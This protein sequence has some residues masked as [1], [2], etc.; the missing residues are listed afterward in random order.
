[1]SRQRTQKTISVRIDRTYIHRPH[2]WRRI[3]RSAVF[4]AV[5]GAIVFLA[6]THAGGEGERIHNPG[7]LTRVHASFENNCAACHDGCDAQGHP[8][9]KFSLAVSDTA[10]LK[11]HDAGVH[12]ANQA[13]M[14][15]MDMSRHPPAAR[16]A[17]CASCHVEHRGQGA[18]VTDSDM[19]CVGCHADLTGKTLKTP[20]TP[21]H[22]TDFSLEGHPRFGRALMKGGKLV[23]PTVLAF[24]H[25]KHLSGILK[26]E[27]QN[28]TF[29]HDPNPAAAQSLTWETSKSA[30]AMPDDDQASPRPLADG[31]GRHRS[32]TQVNF[33]KNCQSCHDLGTLPGSDMA[34]PHE[35]LGQIRRLILT[36]VT[37]SSSPWLKMAPDKTGPR[38][39]AL[40]DRIISALNVP[41]DYSDAVD[42]VSQAVK[43]APLSA[44][45]NL[46]A[47]PLPADL[48]AKLIAAAAKLPT[49]VVAA[50]DKKNVAAALAS[51]T[52]PAM[53]LRPLVISRLRDA[54]A[55]GT[56]GDAKQKILAEFDAVFARYNQDTPDPRLL[57]MYVIYANDA[58]SCV[59]CHTMEG[60]AAGVPTEWMSL[61]S[62]TKT[63][64]ASIFRTTP[65]GIPAGPRRWYVNSE[66]DHDAHRTMSC[67][68]CHSAAL[69]SEKTSD[70]LSP[71]IQWQGLRFEPGSTKLVPAERSCVECHHP[72]NSDG[73]GAAANCTECHVY[74]DRSHEQMNR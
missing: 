29:C 65:T 15:M 39:K 1:M 2:P 36:Y 70:V 16:S 41:S 63:P 38:E 74:H 8:T 42:A 43:A 17:D 18:L 52:Q 47:A 11:C 54:A 32:L 66:F 55:A 13:T 23:D 53:R 57:E 27:Q 69:T 37:S 24:N 62:P 73:P 14:V 26:G 22:V 64:A 61:S 30:Y 51:T 48:Q 44:D 28:C 10:C 58:N 68:E 12:N 9:G 3:R 60:D 6:L 59:K 19:Q 31:T 40:N 7:S 5:A 56:S 46:S 20:V 45:V 35:D 67:V 33:A 50:A 71:D 49:N 4:F 21:L 25:K 34:I 72:D